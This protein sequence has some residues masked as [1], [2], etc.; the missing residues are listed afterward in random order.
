M[1]FPSLLLIDSDA[2][3]EIVLL[4]ARQVIDSRGNPTVEVEVVTQGNGV[5]RAIAPAGASKGKYEAIEKRDSS[6]KRFF[7]KAVYTAV[8]LINTEV[9]DELIGM[10]SRKQWIIDR[11]LIELDGT[12]NKARIGANAIVA[13]SLAVAKAAADTYG[14]PFFWYIGGRRARLLPVPLMNIINGG[15]HAGNEL[16][17]QEFMIVP[18]GADKF[19][20]A[21][22]IGCEVY[23]KL[24]ELLKRT[25][26]KSAIN[27]GDEGGFAPPMKDTKE[28]LDILLKA[29]EEAG[30]S[31]DVV[32][33]ALDA[34]S[35]SFYDESKKVYRIDG[36][37]LSREELIDFFRELIEE[38]PIVSIEDPLEE[39]DFEGFAQ[40]TREIGKRILIVGDDLFVTN[41]K[42][43]SKGIEI[44]AANAI[45]IKP[46]Q[47]GTLSETIEVV[48][49]AK[50][51]DY[52]TI[53]SHRSGESE[54]SSIADLAVGLQTG[55]IKTGAPARGERTAKYNQLLR[56]EEFLGDEAEFLGFRV[57]SSKPK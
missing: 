25:Y 44:G 19:S 7:G 52:K 11:R 1:S 20:E 23:Y 38:Y 5:G 50:R 47:I 41:K 42:R 40:L 6:D 28:A 16:A 49:L 56:I 3:F 15:K 27:V 54:D 9:A 34:A 12:P 14:M 2:N 31:H 39:N 13:T 17:I 26:G 10:D 48:E 55:I 43:L 36:K 35:S 53:M 57:F 29:I 33:L 24:K 30:Y 21:L 22:R 4:K 8:H 45:L 46:N 32:A 18:A 51:S 37:E